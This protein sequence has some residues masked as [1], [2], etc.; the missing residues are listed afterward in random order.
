MT[1]LEVEIATAVREAELP[2]VRLAIP[3]SMLRQTLE[4]VADIYFFFT[5]SLAGLGLAGFL[6]RPADPR[7]W[8]FLL[9]LL[10]FAGSPLPFFGDARF[11][12]PAVPLLTI[13]A[14]WAVLAARDLPRRLV[15]P[16]TAPPP[17][18]SASAAVEG[19]EGEGP[20]SEQDAL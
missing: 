14:A 10:W 11:H 12:V 9:A 16:S 2:G 3:R 5:I 6:L 17:G 20:V 4:R 1:D 18:S 13:S 15:A 7:R 19:A 8:F